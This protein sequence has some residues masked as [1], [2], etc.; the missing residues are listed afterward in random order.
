MSDTQKTHGGGES[1]LPATPVKGG[2]RIAGLE[3]PRGFGCLCVI[4]VHCSIHFAPD[5]LASTRIDFIGQALT[6]FFVLSGFLLYLPYVQRYRDGRELPATGQY[7]MRRVLR[8]FPAYLVIFIIVNFVL[9]AAYIQNPV[10]LAWDNPQ[11]GTGMITDPLKL[12]AYFTL[13]HSLFPSLYQTGINTSW[14]LTA[15]WGFY[16]ALPIIGFMMFKLGRNSSNRMRTAMWAP[17]VLLVI[18]LIANTSI[19]ILQSR[20]GIST[21]EAYWGPNWIAVLARSFFGIADN[22]AFGMLAAVIF[23]GM[24]RNNWWSTTSTSRLQWIFGAV[25]VVG[26]LASMVLFA[27]N[28]RFLAT[29][30]AF[31]GGAFILF[32]IA[33]T[34]RG[35]HSRV[36]EILD[37]TPMRKMGV[38]S[39]SAYLW[40]YPVLIMVY[41]MDLPIP[42]GWAG[43]F[44]GF[45]VVAA[46]SIVLAMITYRLVELPA[47]N[48][49]A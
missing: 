28:P 46:I 2:A 10:S 34:A 1:L 13:T 35:A 9:R 27:T 45:G 36:A 39:L 5:V 38:I 40:H 11:G 49:R 29:V 6:F 17:L 41:R 15:E 42:I 8:V 23:V 30:F 19:G 24:K 3:G 32:I 21:V 18:G 26:V 20:A 4:F 48:Y 37:W 16:L 14:S 22:F 25:T 7:L 33:P 47:M 43:L 12:L 31:A 44:L